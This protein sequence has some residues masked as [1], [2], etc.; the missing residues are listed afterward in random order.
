MVVNDRGRVLLVPLDDILFLRAEEKY[1]AVQTREREHLLD[2]SLTA[3]E[4]E[5]GEAFVRIHRNCLVN[6]R[7]LAGFEHVPGDAGRWEAVLHAWPEKLPVSR[8]QGHVVKAL[9][10][11]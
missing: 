2:E 9:R 5:F 4:E 11:S 10:K 6:R 3:L 1:V 7:H 8:R